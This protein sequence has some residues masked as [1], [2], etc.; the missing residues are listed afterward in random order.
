[1]KN[2]TKKSSLGIFILKNYPPFSHRFQTV[3]L[4]GNSYAKTLLVLLRKISNDNSFLSS[5]VALVMILM[6]VGY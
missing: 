1:M 2:E 3:A 5:F 4:F 6:V